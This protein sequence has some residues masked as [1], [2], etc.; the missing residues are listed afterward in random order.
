MHERG[1]D[2][3]AYSRTHDVD[4]YDQHTCVYMSRRPDVMYNYTDREDGAY[5][6]HT[7]RACMQ[8]SNVK[9]RI[10]ISFAK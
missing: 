6:R 5:G 10:E 7:L 1:S 4:V 3:Y 9:R 2:P 8:R